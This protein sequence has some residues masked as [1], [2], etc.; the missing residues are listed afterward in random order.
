MTDVE[1]WIQELQLRRHP[2]GGWFREIYRAQ[3]TI[4]HQSLPKRFT[5]D[6][7]FSAAIYFLLDGTDFSAFHR[8]KQDELWHFYDGACLTIHI[9]QPAGRYSAVRLGSNVGGGEERMATV[10][11]G[12][13]FGATVDAGTYALVGCTTAPGFD[14]DDLEMPNRTDLLEQYPQHQIMIEQLTR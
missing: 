4:P 6:R 10:Q 13:L 7:S 2:E 1:R 5:G 14:F 8:I 9:I 12:W 11:A 3:E